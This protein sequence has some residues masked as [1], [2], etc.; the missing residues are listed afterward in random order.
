MVFQKVDSQKKVKYKECIMIL[1]IVYCADWSYEQEAAGMAV[2]L[3]EYF[4]HDISMLQLV[5]DG[6]GRF[7]VTL[8]DEMIFSK[9]ETDRFPEY[10]ELKESIKSQ[11][12]N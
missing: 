6:G 12:A 11:K 4:K 10:E 5:P 9:L 3:L 2:R 1:K 8:D 7:E